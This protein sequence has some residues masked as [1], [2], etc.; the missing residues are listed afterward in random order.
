MATA[1][2]ILC[3]AMIAFAL[4]AQTEEPEAPPKLKRGIPKHGNGETSTTAA[5]EMKPSTGPE[6]EPV[7]ERAPAAASESAEGSAKPEAEGAA[8][9]GTEAAPKPAP[10][11][12]EIVTDADGKVVEVRAG[13][14]G[15]KLDP[16][17]EEAREVAF[18]WIESLPNFLCQQITYRSQSDTKPADF[19]MK[20]RVTAELAHEGDKDEFRNLEINGKKLKKGTPEESGTWSVGEFGSMAA[21]VLHPGTQARFEKRGS[22]TIGSRMAKWYDYTVE[23]PNSHWR[24]T[25]EGVTIYPAYKGSIWID[26]ETHRVT[27]LEMTARKLPDDYPMD[28]VEMIVESGKVKIGTTEYLMPVKAGS[29]GCKR[30]TSTCVHNETEYRNYKKF[31][32][33]SSIMTTE[34]TV[35]FEGTDDAK[36]GEE[37]K[38]GAKAPAT[39]KKGK[40]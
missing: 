20:D 33:E 29:L 3:G 23:Q 7:P 37:A 21:D 18:K 35:T 30:G 12:K 22:E 13:G 24:V 16:V 19:K 39:T 4:L 10:I 38:A 8:K 15:P 32:S 31:S 6:P 27:R 17:I 34:S 9:P 11:Y 5:P 36:P 40:K 1:I 2:K 26:E 28:K 14:A 25:F